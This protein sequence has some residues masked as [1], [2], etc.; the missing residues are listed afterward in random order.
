[1]LSCG[2]ALFGDNNRHILW[3]ITVTVLCKVGLDIYPDIWIL[4]FDTLILWDLYHLIY[5][6]LKC[7]YNHLDLVWSSLVGHIRQDDRD[8]NVA[9]FPKK[10]EWMLFKLCLS[11][12]HPRINI[13][14]C[15]MVV[16]PNQ[17]TISLLF[18]KKGPQFDLCPFFWSVKMNYSCTVVPHGHL[19][20]RLHGHY[21]YIW[22]LL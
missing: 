7:P 3:Y 17:S 10:S 2:V 4:L 14:P 12:V 5:V 11:K 9:N 1:M 18:N 16:I 15:N 6:S 19:N 22:T 20:G 21:I 13:L 8:M